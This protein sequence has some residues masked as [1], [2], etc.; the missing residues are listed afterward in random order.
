MGTQDVL[1]EFAKVTKVEAAQQIELSPDSLSEPQFEKRVHAEIDR[2]KD[3]TAAGDA[4]IEQLENELERQR[5]S[6]SVD[7]ILAAATN[8]RVDC[9]LIEHR[10]G[11]AL[12]QIDERELVQINSALVRV[13][14][15][16]GSV[17]MCADH[18]LG[19]SA[20]AAIYRY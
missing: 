4:M 6:R 1:G 7:Q 11:Y 16:G 8:G 15:M 2:E 12:D 17:A 18:S 10:V 20:V 14:Q 19:R 9:L 13:L 5:G 3:V